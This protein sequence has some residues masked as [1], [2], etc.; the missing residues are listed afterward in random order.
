ML[1]QVELND[2]FKQKYNA[3]R[4]V[5]TESQTKVRDAVDLQ[6]IAD[7]N[8]HP[9][10]T[11]GKIEELKMLLDLNREAVS[12]AR[13]LATSVCKRCPL[14]RLIHVRLGKQIMGDRKVEH[15]KCEPPFTNVACDLFGP[16]ND[17]FVAHCGNPKTIT[18]E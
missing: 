18:N 9:P 6:N 13:Q 10:D 2:E 12:R 17:K 11:A 14:C 8:A 16:F 15:L 3:C 4:K 5:Y 1:D 7:M